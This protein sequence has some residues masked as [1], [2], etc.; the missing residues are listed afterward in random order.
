MLL[1]VLMRNPALHVPHV[2]SLLFQVF[3]SPYANVLL[4]DLVE[5][6][7]HSPSFLDVAVLRYAVM[8]T[9]EVFD[10]GLL[11]LLER[12]NLLPRVSASCLLDAVASASPTLWTATRT[13]KLAL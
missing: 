11:T 4:D 2:P 1:A 7:T 13:V 5:K 3:N 12:P 6:N 8:H 9:E 10:C